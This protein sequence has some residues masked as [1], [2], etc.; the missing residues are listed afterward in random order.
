MNF[1]RKLLQFQIKFKSKVK[2]ILQIINTS[3]LLK[4]I[5]FSKTG[6]KWCFFLWYWPLE[7][8]NII[9]IF[10]F[11]VYTYPEYL[12]IIKNINPETTVPSRRIPIIKYRRNENRKSPFK[13]HNSKCHKQDLPG[14]SK[15]QTLSR[16]G[17]LH[18]LKVSL[19]NTQ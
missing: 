2:Q 6:H 3:F 7:S 1:K 8:I 15:R 10:K 13:H 9:S 19:A 4:F 5:T 17:H 16:T 18:S 12:V 14:D 11:W